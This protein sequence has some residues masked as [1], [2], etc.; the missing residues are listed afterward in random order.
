MRAHVSPRLQMRLGWLVAA[1]ALTLLAAQFVAAG[2]RAAP[3]LAPS[4]CMLSSP[5]ED[6]AEPADMASLAEPRP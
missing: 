4:V 5:V 1:L 2:H 3:R 6:E